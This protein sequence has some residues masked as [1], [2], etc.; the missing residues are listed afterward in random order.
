MWQDEYD[1]S[2][3]GFPVLYMALAVSVFVLMILMV[4]L[5]VNRD[6]KHSTA[7]TPINS[8]SQTAE[9]PVEEEMSPYAGTGLVSSDLDFWDMYPKEDEDKEAVVKD[10]EKEKDKAEEEDEEEEKKEDPSTDGKHTE[11]VDKNGKSEWVLINPKWEKNTYDYTNL[12]SKNNLL[13]Y[14]ADGKQVSFLGVDLS[15]YQKNVDF[16]TLK[17]AGVDFCMLRTGA[18]GYETGVL[19]PDE[20]FDTFLKEAEE[21]EMPVGVYFFSQA[22]TVQEATEEADF[23]LGKLLEHKIS[24]PVAFDMEFIDNDTSRVETLSREERTQIA[25]TFLQ[26]IEASGYTG[27]LY[28]NKEW[29]LKRIDLSKFDDYDIW[30]AEEKD[31]PDYPYRFSMWQYSRQGEVDGINGMVDL[32]ISFIDY[33][34]R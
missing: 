15:K 9:E 8:A 13:R 18:R 16:Y 21:A 7:P 25:L 11:I 32:N 5:F 30:L 10:K 6:K 34:A 1:D 26:K 17:N 2:P 29:L 4:V 23:V 14:Y 27:M 28:G 22:I 19:Q 33:S 20:S 12:V 24:Y 31:I 3:G